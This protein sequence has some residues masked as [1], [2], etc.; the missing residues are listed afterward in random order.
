MGQLQP[1]IG[2]ASELGTT[3]VGGGRGGWG[4]LAQRM[5]LT[6][7]SV[8][9]PPGAELREGISPRW[10]SSQRSVWDSCSRYL[11]ALGFL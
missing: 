10:G 2:I 8:M 4:L 7:E 6:L 5:Q 9:Q 11:G 1:F 3:S